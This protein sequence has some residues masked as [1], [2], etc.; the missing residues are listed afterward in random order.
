M[1]ETRFDDATAMLLRGEN[2]PGHWQPDPEPKQ[3]FDPDCIQFM[4][5]YR[6]RFKDASDR[7][8]KDGVRS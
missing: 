8:V 1:R 3:D 4:L 7:K 2:V 6:K 5:D